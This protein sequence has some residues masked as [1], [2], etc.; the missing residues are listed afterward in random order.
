M[1]DRSKALSEGYPSHN[2]PHLSDEEATRITHEDVKPALQEFAVALNMAGPVSLDKLALLLEHV[3]K[4]QRSSDSEMI[5]DQMRLDRWQ[6]MLTGEESCE[7]LA[8][9]ITL[10]LAT[11]EGIRL[12]NF[13]VR[14]FA[15]T[16]DSM[17]E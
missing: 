5:A 10:F 1:T 3:I 14:I 2:E 6:D 7:L 15:K 8:E 13:F 17:F 4:E 12:Y 9:R 11:E 16:T